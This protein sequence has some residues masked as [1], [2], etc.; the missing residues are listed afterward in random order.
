MSQHILDLLAN[1]SSQKPV[2]FNVLLDECGLLPKTLNMILDAMYAQ[3][4]INQATVTRK[5]IE[6]REVWLTGVVDKAQ[7]QDIVI[8]KGYTPPS[9]HQ[10]R[11]P[12]RDEKPVAAP[13]TAAESKSEVPAEQEAPMDSNEEKVALKDIVNFVILKGRIK[14]SA[15]YDKFVWASKGNLERLQKDVYYL[16]SQDVLKKIKGNTRL[17]DEVSL[18]DKANDFLAKELN[19]TNGKKEPKQKVPPYKIVSSEALI[20]TAT[21]GKIEAAY[22]PRF[23]DPEEVLG[24]SKISESSIN[25]ASDAMLKLLV[26][27]SQAKQKIRFAMTSDQTIMLFGI[28]IGTDVIELDAEDTQLLIEF[29]DSA[30]LMLPN[31]GEFSLNSGIGAQG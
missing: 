18:G 23:K 6:Q 7:R 11:P 9:G 19:K 17:D 2:P 4:S 30:S 28:G 8:N 5:G 16:I 12:R 10:I 14:K 25:D 22:R 27:N 24:A 31:H 26:P 21:K 3:H 13:I 15:I 1:S 29:C 20:S